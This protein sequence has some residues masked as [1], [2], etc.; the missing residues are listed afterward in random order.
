MVND[1]KIQ[2]RTLGAIFHIALKIGV[3][4]EMGMLRKMID[5]AWT[6]TQYLFSASRFVNPVD[7]GI[8]SLFQIVAID[9]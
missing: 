7:P 1:S 2:S 9:A 4:K 5:K 6:K 3:E 8:R